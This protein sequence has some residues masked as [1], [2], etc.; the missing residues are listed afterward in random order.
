MSRDNYATLQTTSN[1]ELALKDVALTGDLRGSVF[2]ARLR[3]RFFNSTG[4]H[5][6]VVYSFP[7]PWGATLLGVDVTLGGR[8]LE[9]M[10]VEKKQA[11]SQYLDSLAEG[12]A[13]IMLERGNDGAYVMNLGNLAPDEECAISIRYAQ[14]LQFEQGGLRLL[15]PT[16]IAPRYGDLVRDGGLAPHQVPLTD[17][18]A[19]YPFDL[20]LS[21]HGALAQARI[22]SPSHPISVMGGGQGEDRMM[23]VSLARQARLDRDFIL[24]VDRLTHGSTTSVA[25]DFAHENQ[26]VAVASFCPEIQDEAERPVAI[27]MLVD[28]SGS[29]GGDSIASARVALRSILERLGEED[30]FS[31]SK[32]GSTVVHRSRGLWKVTDQTRAS[33]TAWINQLSANL[34]G[35]EME[36][37]LRSTFEIA[38]GTQSDVLLITD[39]EIA[40]VDS[41]VATAVA[42]G[43]RVFVVGIGSSAYE[44]LLRQLAEKTGGA[45]DFVAPGEDVAPAIVRMFSRLRSAVVDDVRIEWP[46][47]NPPSWASE[48][49]RPVFQGDTVSVCAWMG[50]HPAGRV[51]LMGRPRGSSQLIEIGSAELGAVEAAP[52]ISRL[53]ASMRAGATENAD[54]RLA[55]ALQYQL[56]TVQ[57]NFLLVAVRDAGEKAKEMPV[58]RHVPQMSPAGHAGHGSVLYSMANLAVPSVLRNPRQA[59]TPLFDAVDIPA[60][61]RRGSDVACMIDDEEE[62]LDD[63]FNL[64]R[65]V[66]AQASCY[67]TVLDELRAGRKAT[68]WMWFIFPQ[69]RGLGTSAN[70]L[71]FGISGEDEARAYLAH[72]VLGA[73]LAACLALILSVPARTTQEIFGAVDALKLCSCLTLFEAAAKDPGMFTAA[74]QKYFGGNRDERTLGLLGRSQRAH[75]E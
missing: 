46:Q 3:Q 38:E 1:E 36:S 23:T 69:I 13:A 6:E 17:S 27:K 11:E 57:T 71:H 37:A 73:R 55:L 59:A 39:G 74:L 29:M 14:L 65:F 66:A 9:G 52:A 5:A 4:K 54:E 43:Q 60:F 47:D 40:G 32:F 8:S 61:L 58:L 48:V 30:R 12:D 35:T 68:H 2:E 51:R 49:N 15:V 34:G 24:I 25:T 22:L 28:C 31:L 44:P 75:T 41:V 7:L 62:A 50:Q 42:S 26:Y 56:V 45:C 10:V 63:P 18:Q 70:S 33:G 72:P 64:E 21:L 19:E 67:D 16:V 20:T 53:A